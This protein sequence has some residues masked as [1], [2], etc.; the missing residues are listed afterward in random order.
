MKSLILIIVLL[1]T[2]L[3]FAQKTED[4]KSSDLKSKPG[5]TTSETT[6]KISAQSVV[7]SL[8]IKK[9]SHKISDYIYGKGNATKKIVSILEK[10]HV[11]KDLIQK[12]IHY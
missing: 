1:A 4:K 8:K 10:I 2:Q 3:S 9:S 5:K 6:Q 7:K 12:Q 11:N